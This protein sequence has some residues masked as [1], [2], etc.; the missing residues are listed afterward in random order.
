MRKTAVAIC[1]LILVF[2]TELAL[3]QTGRL[4]LFADP[5]G[6][7]CS[8]SD[9]TSGIL[10]VYVIHEHAVGVTAVQFSAPKPSCMTG[11]TWLLDTLSF[12]VAI[13]NSQVGLTV[14]Y[15]ACRSS[16]IHVVTISYAV[17]GW[18]TAN[19]A[20]TVLPD[21]AY[22]RIKVVNCDFET[23]DGEGSTT[24]INSSFPCTC[25]DP[26]PILGVSPA[27]LHIPGTSAHEAVSI[28]N[29]G[30]GSLYWTVSSDQA[31]MTA[32]PASGT[33]GGTVGVYVDRHGLEPG[34]YY[35]GLTVAS[36]GGNAV[37]PVDMVVTGGILNVD[38]NILVFD[39][40]VQTSM[41]SISNS[42]GGTLNWSLSV[43]D[44]WIEASPMTG[45]GNAVITV[46]VDVASLPCCG[47]SLGRIRVDS[48][49]GSE[50]VEIHAYPAPRPTGGWIGIYTDV[51]GTQ[52][53]LS[54]AT[55][56][57]TT[58]HVV[59][60]GDFGATACAY[61]A[62]KPSCFTA[63]YLSDT[64]VF[65]VTI[66]NSQ[67]GVSIGYGSCR[68]GAIRVQSIVF[69]TTGTTPQCCLYPILGIP[70]S[71]NVEVVDCLNALTTAYG[72]TSVVN[73]S[74]SCTCGSV[75]VEESTW[76]RVKSLY[77]GE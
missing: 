32:N 56:G 38:P 57:L 47:M 35:G 23:L 30:G 36:N 28:Q 25:N 19:C 26:S 70:T 77:S 44:P 75:R 1:L 41:F 13:G 63:T 33:G 24:Y 11:A 22:N 76:G 55:V 46:N 5:Q 37:I 27:S 51:G 45:T 67:A 39:P 40:S 29:N 52:C 65:P 16:P 74:G 21:Q 48:N 18:T 43:F 59:H 8:L 69:F 49:W 6:T 31:W 14:G 58:Y 66:G 4:C 20:Y 72:V 60:H 68:S 54:D 62:P 64:N 3:A 42:G 9:T 17:K 71:G 10:K 61:W 15:G 12:P 2:S 7:N 50:M 53:N 73:P 34:T